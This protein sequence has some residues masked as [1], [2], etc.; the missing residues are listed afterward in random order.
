MP[1]FVGAGDRLRDVIGQAIVGVG[2]DR[3]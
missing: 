2:D 1:D 3:D